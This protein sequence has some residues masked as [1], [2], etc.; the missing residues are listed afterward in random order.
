MNLKRSLFVLA[1]LATVI[2]LAAAQSLYNNGTFGRTN[3]SGPEGL[4]T[5]G[6][7]AAPAGFRNSEIASAIGSPPANVFGFGAQTTENNMVADDFVVTGNGWN[8]TSVNLFLYQT[9]NSG[10]IGAPGSIDGGLFQIRTPSS[11]AAGP[12]AVVATGTF[13]SSVY[14]DLL[15]IAANTP[16]T[17]R[18][19][20]MLS[21]NMVVSLAPGTYWIAYSATGQGSSGPWAPYV[22]KS[23]PNGYHDGSAN[24]MASVA[25][26][27]WAPALEGETPTQPVDLPFYVNGA[28][29]PEPATM[30]LA[31][32]AVAAIVRR[33]RKA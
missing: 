10:A 8:V 27:P 2:P 9:G 15:R 20:Q 4:A 5:P 25:G 3:V 21:V 12:G 29:V 26:S 17:A 16:G 7:I 23:T 1:A 31:G 14:T 6:G 13:Q 24:A 11:V 33:R 30:A 32:L 19:I 22:T 28:P 18:Q